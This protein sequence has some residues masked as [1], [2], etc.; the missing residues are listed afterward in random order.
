[1]PGVCNHRSP[2][3]KSTTSIFEKNCRRIYN[4]RV[5]F[6]G[7][8]LAAGGCG[9]PPWHAGDLPGLEFQ[10]LGFNRP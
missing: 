5:K 2:K 3:F 8:V 1:M 6:L 9:S 4:E 10:T 7:L